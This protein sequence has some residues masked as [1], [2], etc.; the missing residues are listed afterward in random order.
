M[1]SECTRQ[2]VFPEFDRKGRIRYTR[3]T[4]RWAWPDGEALMAQE[5]LLVDMF[6][7]MLDEANRRTQSG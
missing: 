4:E 6:E 5:T 1:F 2:R 3:R 7:V